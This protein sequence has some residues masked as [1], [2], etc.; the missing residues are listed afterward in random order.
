MTRRK[1]QRFAEIVSF[2][3]VYELGFQEREEGLKLKGK[4]LECHFK[5]N[6]PIVLELGCGKGEYTLGLADKYPQ[7]NFIGVD[8]K[9]NRIWRGAKTVLENK[10][11]NAAFLRT[12]IDFIESCFLKDEVDE[13]W[14]TFPD[15]QPQKS[16][17]RKRL[18][19]PVFLNRYK[20]ILKPGG[21]I[22][23]KTDNRPLWEYTTEVIVENNYKLVCATD[24]LYNNPLAVF[25]EAASIQTHYEALFKSKG[26][27]ICY[28]EFMF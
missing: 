14:I 7:K 17:I 20:N 10:I 27:T 11:D 26:F 19:S 8:I 5:N 28:L 23:L 16:R 18:T 15:P 6:N 21:L 9:G 25:S 3:H 1:L 2:P 22:H 24:N 13:I 4:W 12:R